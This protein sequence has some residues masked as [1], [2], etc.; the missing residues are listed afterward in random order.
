MS[1]QLLLLYLPVALYINVPASARTWEGLIQVIPLLSIITFST[2]CVY[3][4]WISA[5]DFI[6]QRLTERFGDNF[7]LEFSFLAVVFTILIST[8][9]AALHVV[10][11]QQLTRAIITL[12]AELWPAIMPHSGAPA[13]APETLVFAQ[14]VGYGFGS[15]SCYRHFISRTTPAPTSN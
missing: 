1:L 13:I 9:L 14:R 7:L 8:G 3:F 2:F 15:S 6:Q 10:T 11:F 5:I 12:L 4:V